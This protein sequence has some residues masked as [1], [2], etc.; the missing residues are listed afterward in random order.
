[1]IERAKQRDEQAF[2]ELIQRYMYIIQ[3]VI[4]KYIHRIPGYDEED[5]CK[6]VILAAWEMISELRGGE[7][8]FRCWLG[9]KTNWICLDLL[10]KQRKEGE[11]V[12]LETFMDHESEYPQHSG[13]SSLEMIVTEERKRLLQGTIHALPEPY[14]SAV[15]LRSQGL[16]YVQIA[17]IK[18]ISIKTVG[19]Q[20]NRG[21]A[22]VRKMLERQ[23]ALEA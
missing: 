22:M 19:S 12:S 18:G 23:G 5:I 16:S 14:K 8:S 10:R 13:P 2:L 20:L 11:P 21:I 7:E 1:M 4:A 17:A 15:S 6:I 9:R 3:A